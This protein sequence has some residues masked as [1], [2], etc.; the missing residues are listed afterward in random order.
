MKIKPEQVERTAE[1][2]RLDF[3]S[4]E[5][6]RYVDQFSE[7]L[8]YFEQLQ[9]VD[10]SSIEPLYHPLPREDTPFRE[11]RVRPE[12]SSEEALREAPESAQGHFKVPRVIES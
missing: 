1:L 9:E 8:G 2:A 5:L 11:D 4:D 12:L 10:T 7:L 6:T 3:S